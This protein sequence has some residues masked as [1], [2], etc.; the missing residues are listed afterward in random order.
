ME[1]IDQLI[2]DSEDFLNLLVN[3]YPN[4]ELSQIVLVL[5]ELIKHVEKIKELSGL[6]KKDLVI[7]LLNKVIDKTDLPGDDNI[8]DPILKSMVPNMIDTLIKV[9]KNQ[10]KL[11]IRKSWLKKLKD[12][13]C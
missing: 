2:N 12:C 3:N 1:N 13:C 8:L 9:D 6:Q 7:K 5:P 10:I 11:K 4:F